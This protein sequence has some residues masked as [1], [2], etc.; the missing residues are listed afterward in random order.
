M[1]IS[2]NPSLVSLGKQIRAKRKTEGRYGTYLADQLGIS[3][4]YLVK[5]EG[6]HAL[7][8]G[9][10]LDQIQDILDIDLSEYISMALANQREFRFRKSK[11][12][13]DSQGLVLLI[14]LYL[15][16]DRLIEDEWAVLNDAIDK[17]D[18]MY[19]ERMRG[20]KEVETNE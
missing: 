19:R 11:L 9:K 6:G 12:D 4:A 10:V 15:H 16:Y 3:P 17:V 20:G 14:Y 1:S 7:P 8:A 2:P 5:I 18:V 13:K